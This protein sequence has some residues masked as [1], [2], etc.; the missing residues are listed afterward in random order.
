MDPIGVESYKF[1]SSSFLNNTTE[2][3][4]IL[5]ERWLDL[6]LKPFPGGFF[7]ELGVLGVTKLITQHITCFRGDI[8][9]CLEERFTIHR[10]F[11][12]DYTGD[13]HGKAGRIVTIKWAAEMTS[14]G[15]SRTVEQR[16]AIA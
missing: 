6:I 5:H 9:C 3:M 12:N 11:C 7:S 1:V 15:N 10:L 16:V 14:F 2:S 4:A 13:I 8:P